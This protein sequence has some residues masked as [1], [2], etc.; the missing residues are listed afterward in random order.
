[1]RQPSSP[2]R[3]QQL[4]VFVLDGYEPALRGLRDQLE[5]GGFDVVG[6]S[7]SARAAPG[8]ILALHPDVAVLALR[9][10][11]GS[12]LEVLHALHA[13]DRS[14]HCLMLD[15]FRDDKNLRA[16]KAG[17]ANGYI[18]KEIDGSVL[19]EALHRVAAGEFLF[20]A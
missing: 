15:T 10:Q 14:V 9:L 4:R 7:L 16:A 11:D 19:G 13:A 8:M 17:G 1:M 12:G 3:R 5:S 18:L 2:P 20:A 6:T